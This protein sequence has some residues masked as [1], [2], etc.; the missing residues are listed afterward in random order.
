LFRAGVGRADELVEWLRGAVKRDPLNPALSFWVTSILD[1]A[2]DTVGSLAEYERG[3]ALFDEE[4][5]GHFNAFVTLLGSGEHERA[6]AFAQTRISSPVVVEVL[7]DFDRPESALL[8]L[9]SLYESDAPTDLRSRQTVSILAAY[10]G[11]AALSLSAM[12][13]SLNETGVSPY[14]WRPVFSPVRRHEDFKVLAR[15]FGF[16]D[17]WR[18]YGW[19]DSCRPLGNDDFECG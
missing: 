12:R 5:I 7:D 8:T 18:E 11:D 15:D 10:F 2:G 4:W 6:K 13:D 1:A 9:R 3:R 14:L 19:P 16:V 17:Y